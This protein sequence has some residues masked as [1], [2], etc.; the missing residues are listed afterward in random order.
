[1]NGTIKQY[2]NIHITK[3]SLMQKMIFTNSEEKK[4]CSK[5]L[6]LKGVAYH[7]VLINFIGLN[8]K[9]QIEYKKIADVYKYDK[10]IRNRLYKFLAAFEE[11]IRAFIANSYNHGLETLDLG[12]DITT[13]LKNGS[14]IAFELEDLN[15]SK[16]LDIVKKFT[17]KDLKRLFPNNDVKNLKQNLIAAKELRNA[18]SH[19]RILLLYD[20]FE[21]CYINGEA[22]SDLTSNII[23]IVNLIDVYYKRFLIDAINDC[24]NDK[25]DETFFIPEHLVIKL[26]L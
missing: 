9:G 2:L 1:M 26:D 16:L 20:E 13:N 24:V 3:T 6:D 19:H 18:I 12:D 4:R 5:Y 10:R 22:K 21:E 25:R 8:E 23:N 7:V 15:F 14:N 11:Q 17:P